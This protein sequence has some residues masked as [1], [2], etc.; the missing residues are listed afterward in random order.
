MGDNNGIQLVRANKPASAFLKITLLIPMHY[1][2]VHYVTAKLIELFS[3][4]FGKSRSD[5]KCLLPVHIKEMPKLKIEKSSRLLHSD[6]SMT[7][8]WQEKEIEN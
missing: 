7:P 1:L 3:F 8:Y 6:Q 4:S 5:S 2:L